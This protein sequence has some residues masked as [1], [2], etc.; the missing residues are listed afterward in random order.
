MKYLVSRPALLAASV[1]LP[2]GAHAQAFRTYL[3]SYGSDANAGCT[4][5]APCRLL[6]AALN[7]VLDGGEVWIL[8]SA[9]FNAGTVDIG[10]SVSIIAVPGQVASIV[11]AGGL[12]AISISTPNLKIGLR[13]IVIPRNANNPG[14]NGI[15]ISSNSLLSVEDCLFS[16]LANNGIFAHGAASVIHV[17][18]SVFRNV[19]SFAVLAEGGPVV[20]ITNSQIL[21]SNGVWAYATAAS[22]TTVNVTDSTISGASFS[23]VYARAIV[24]G[25]EAKVYL[26]RTTIHHSGT[27]LQ[28]ETANGNGAA[29]IYVG[30]SMISES[31]NGWYIF[32]PGASIVS[33]GNNQFS[34]NA[35]NVGAMTS[36]PLQ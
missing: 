22:S 29:T 18:N 5:S 26:T 28:S 21:S 15:D 25:A 33:Y 9:N 24:P 6:P 36:N 16:N 14:T 8:D 35:A 10:K 7:A 30:G 20:N 11:A 13:N 23:A 2:L 27:A 34:G 17:K 12:P 32:N 31:S 19:A 4:V 3:A 1:L